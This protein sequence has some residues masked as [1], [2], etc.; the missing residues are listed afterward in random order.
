MGVTWEDDV[1]F[2][3]VEEESRCQSE[4]QTSD[5]TVYKIFGFEGITLPYSLTVIDTPG[6]GDTRGID[7]DFIIRQTLFNLFRSH[8]GIHEITAVG[9]VLKASDNRLSDRLRYVFDSTQSLFGNDMEN[10]TV[11]LITHS[12]GLTPRN[13]LEALK[14]SNV[15]CAKNK[16]NQ[17]VH[18]LFN[19][20][21][22]QDRTKHTAN[23][24]YTNQISTEGTK[25][26]TRFLGKT[27]PQKLNRTVEVLGEQIRLTAC[28]Q[29][30]H[31]DQWL[32]E[33]FQ[34]VI[35]LEQIALNPDSLST[36]V[37]LDVL[38]EMMREKRDTKKV[39]KL[40]EIRYRMDSVKGSRDAQVYMGHRG[41]Q[42]M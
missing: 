22:R 31:G 32:E 8:G 16:N 37:H 13:A 17:A 24:R 21:Q 10:R 36:L 4:S 1:W 11:L 6:W 2:Q 40:Q 18:F 7:H 28:M 33:S 41:K 20:C 26:F 39:Q 27:T 35:R 30:K 29:S 23:L 25:Q 38:I 15:K 34:H 19:N 42:L 3:I 14:V 12:D 5:V 9:L